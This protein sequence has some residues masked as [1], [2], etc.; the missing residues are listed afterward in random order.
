MK[1]SPKQMH[2]H[3]KH[4][5]RFRTN[6]VSFREQNNELHESFLGE[7][8]A[9]ALM[10]PPIGKDLNLLKHVR[11]FNF[12]VL[13]NDIHTFQDDNC[14]VSV[15]NCVTRHDKTLGQFD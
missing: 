5:I 1:T 6:A 7:A 10:T 15:S 11:H 13:H 3:K 8:N 9:N 14:R 12:V 4:E 2:T